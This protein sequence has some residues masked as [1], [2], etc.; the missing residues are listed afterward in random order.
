MFKV[1]GERIDTVA[2]SAA[3]GVRST[4]F[5]GWYG[6]EAYRIHKRVIELGR[7]HYRETAALLGQAMGAAEP[8]PLVVGGH[9]AA[10]RSSSPFFPPGCGSRLAGSFAADPH[11]LT[12]AR[13]GELAAPVIEH[14][15]TAREHRLMS[16]IR[17]L[18][19]GGLAAAGPANAPPQ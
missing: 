1:A 10:S 19:P 8:Q 11:T 16:Q 14:W 9:A 13:V 15:V 12:P 6:L 17:A 7:H 18:P 4:N 3:E 5:G 2:Q